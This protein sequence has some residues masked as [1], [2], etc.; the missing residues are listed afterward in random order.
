MRE[1]FR[2]PTV[3]GGAHPGSRRSRRL[4]T[5]IEGESAEPVPERFL[6]AAPCYHWKA[7]VVHDWWVT[8]SKV[9]VTAIVAR[10]AA[11]NEKC[12]PRHELIRNGYDWNNQDID[13][14]QDSNSLL[15]RRNFPDPKTKQ[16]Q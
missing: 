5:V 14:N 9:R 8:G 3:M 16:W 12:C 6:S 15:V 7:V 13:E 10:S 11:P 2:L 1:N 4:T